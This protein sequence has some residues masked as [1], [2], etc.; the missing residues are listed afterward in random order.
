MKKG[1]L[2]SIAAS[3][4]VFAGGDIAPV[5]PVQPTAAPAA[6]DFWGSIGARYE[7]IDDG[8]ANGEF[9]D[10][11]NNTFKATVVL[12]VE[13][14]LGYGFGFGAELAGSFITNGKFEKVG[15]KREDVEIS[16]LY[17]TYKAG[18]TA[19]KAGR[20]ALPKSLSPWAWFDRTVGR[21]DTTFEG[22]VVVNTDIADTVLVGAW[23]PRAGDGTD[24]G[25]VNGVD[26]KGLFMLTAQ[27]KG[28]ADTTLTGSVYYVPKSSPSEAK[29]SIWA[30][31]ETKVNGVDLGLQVAYAKTKD[32]K[33][34]TG[35]AAYVGTNFNGLDAKLTLAYLKNGATTLALGGTSAFWGNTGYSST[36]GKGVYDSGA[37]ETIVKLDLGYKI[38]GYGTVYGGAAYDKVSDSAKADKMIAARIGYKFTVAGVNAK[39]E[40]RY[41]KV[42]G[43]TDAHKKQTIRLEGVYKF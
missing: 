32:T 3:A 20:Q 38:D 42:S 2:L 24:F 25:P 23:I 8:T 5:Q 14:E 39:I 29:Y 36:N 10:T 17:L 22:I 35:V 21:L 9:G 27:Y 12:G 26:N 6:C 41:D 18:N 40:Y 33:A 43:G 37:K 19:V 30:T 15:P 16:Q 7:F 11:E 13:K 31:G 4:V 1:L 28:I 34:T